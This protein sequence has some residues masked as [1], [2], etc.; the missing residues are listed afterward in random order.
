MVTVSDTELLILRLLPFAMFAF[1]LVGASVALVS[2][3]KLWRLTRAIGHLLL[4][5]ACI[6]PV[7]GAV[8]EI[9]RASYLSQRMNEGVLFTERRI[10][11]GV[12]LTFGLIGIGAVLVLRSERRRQKAAE[13]GATDNPDDAQRLRED[14]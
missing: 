14:Y 3:L 12:P 6:L 4:A 1:S 11:M 2:F 10:E 8:A 7:A 5:I 13:P 9:V